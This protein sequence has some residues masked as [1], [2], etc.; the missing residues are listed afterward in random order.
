MLGDRRNIL[1]EMTDEEKLRFP[2]GGNIALGYREQL[3]CEK[4]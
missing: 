1:V 3:K 2:N 4:E